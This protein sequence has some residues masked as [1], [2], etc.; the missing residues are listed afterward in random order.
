MSMVSLFVPNISE[1][2]RD[3]IFYK[4]YVI[5]CDNMIKIDFKAAKISLH[6]PKFNSTISPIVPT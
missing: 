5:K 1:N 2:E 3:D 4:K 6:S